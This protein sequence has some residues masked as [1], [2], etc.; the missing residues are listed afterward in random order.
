MKEL[1]PFANVLA[2]LKRHNIEFIVCGGLAGA[3]CGFVWATEDIDIL[4]SHDST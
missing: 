4:V 2:H 1:L 3:F